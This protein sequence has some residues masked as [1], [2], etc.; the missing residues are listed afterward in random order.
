MK[1]LQISP[2]FPYPLDS[3]GR[4]GIYNIVKNLAKLG[5]KIYFVA[6]S[7]TKVP[8]EYI[9]HFKSF[10]HPFV[11]E[12]DTNNTFPRMLKYF[13]LN[14]PILTE[15]FFRKKT[16][17]TFKD[18]LTKINFDLIHLDHT[19]NI[20]VGRWISQLTGK[21][22]GL[23]LHNIEWKIWEGLRNEQVPF[24]PQ[25]IF[26]TQQTH[27]LREKERQAIEI[28]EVSFACTD[29]DRKLALEL[30]PNARVLVASPGVDMNL[31]QPKEIER[32]RYEII[33]ASTFQW[34]PN[35]NGLKW[36]LDQVL[37]KVREKVS[38]AFVTV[39]GKNPP[40]FLKKYQNI[41]LLGYVEDIKPYYNRGSLLVVP[42]F[43]GSGVRVKI[44][45]AMAMQLP[46]VSTNVG[47]EGIGATPD[48]G[49]LIADNPDE[50]AD[51][52]VE[53]IKNPEKARKIGS[54][55]RKFIQNNFSVETS[56]SIMFNEYKRILENQIG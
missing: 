14:K 17:E 33:F 30:V 47:A 32:N 13:I 41:N 19:S 12:L 26:L 40:D 44:L 6:F 9:E 11:I 15:K 2:Q 45:E 51:K 52:I 8:N 4:I 38:E 35:V 7:K 50:F 49:I 28:A 37:P 55:A 20:T 56:I 5:A 21:P 24:S 16:I 36:F 1:I 18:I 29:Y 22:V 3:G 23:R 48:E 43:V 31:W 42:L 34:L 39:I 53:L 46:V 54:N 10:C 27:L 25:W